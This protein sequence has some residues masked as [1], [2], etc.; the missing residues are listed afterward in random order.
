MARRFTNALCSSITFIV[1]GS[2]SGEKKG[3]RLAQSVASGSDHPKAPIRII[4][5]GLNHVTTHSLLYNYI[6]SN[7]ILNT[8]KNFSGEVLT[9]KVR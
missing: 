9:T 7:C 5:T 8:T 2:Y 3:N 6:R 1:I 4:E